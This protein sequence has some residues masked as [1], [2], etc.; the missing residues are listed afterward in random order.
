MRNIILICS[1]GMSTSML[2]RKMQDAAS[3]QGYEATIAAF[4]AS[5]VKEVTEH[6]DVVLL[7]PQVRFQLAKIKELVP[8]PVEVIDVSAYGMMDG[9]KVIARVKEILGDA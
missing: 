4:P 7:G 8:C 1:A 9:G 3:K 5:Q 2:V 6:A